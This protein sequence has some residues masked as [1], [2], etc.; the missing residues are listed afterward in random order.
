MHDLVIRGGTLVD[1]T[2][3]TRITGDVA[4]D[5]D[6][7]TAVGEVADRGR[8]QVDAEGLLV[9]PGWVDIH[10]HYDGQATWDSELTPSAWHGVTTTV[11]GN[12]SVGF[13]PVRPGS[14]PYLISLMEGVED[15]PGSVLSEGVEFGWESFADYLDALERRPRTMDVGA[16]V[17]HAAVRFYV[18][19]DRGAEH[20]ERPTVEEAAA[21]GRLVADALQAGALG[22]TTSRTKKHRAADGRFTPGLTAGDE[23]LL[24]IAEAMGEVGLGVLQANSDFEDPSELG[25]LR[26]MAEV[27]GRPVSF[28]LLQVDHAPGRWK[29]LLAGVHDA[30]A[31][32]VPMRAQVGCRPIGILMGLEA[33]LHPF[34]GHRTFKE[35]GP[36]STAELV[37]RLRR[38]EVRARILG[39][40]QHGGFADWMAHALTQTFELGD[41][42]DYEPD[43]AR[44]IAAR[45][46]R[47]GVTALELVYDLLLGDDGRALLYYPFENYSDGHL[48]PVRTMLTNEHTVSGLSDGGAHVA[49]ICDASFPTFLLTHWARDR[50]RGERVALELLVRK[51]TRDTARAVGLHDR[52]VIAPGLRAD[53]NVVDLD[54]LR[55]LP[56]EMVHDLPAGGRRLVQRAAGYRHTFVAGVETYAD[57][58]WT[59]AT[60]GH[61]IRGAQPGA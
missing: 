23:E 30:A 22:F 17:P 27:S 10:T 38:P 47:D 5:G 28:S 57:G 54:G 35:L 42:P 13:A 6:R 39:E 3:G 48:E 20:A 60:P 32:G 26:R 34:A 1:G 9:L 50:R 7:I 31:A 14:E 16:Q 33:S 29:D 41:P 4:V 21:M 2:G 58:D 49:T 43:P 12:C 15:I 37:G 51:Q 46:T 25:L 44:S 61:L 53:L 24:T 45:A 11:F 52:G 19:G 56:P 36:L 59:G 8:R 55:L 40:E 18:M